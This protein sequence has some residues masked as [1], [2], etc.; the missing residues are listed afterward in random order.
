MP[1]QVINH[2][3]L[4]STYPSA[5]QIVEVLLILNK[6]ANPCHHRIFGHIIRI[7]QQYHRLLIIKFQFKL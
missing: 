4:L 3:K 2:P 1:F 5:I 6:S 7:M